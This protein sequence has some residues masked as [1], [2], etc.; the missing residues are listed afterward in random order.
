[1]LG[2]INTLV[3]MEV[4]TIQITITISIIITNT[5]PT[6]TSIPL[7]PI[8]LLLTLKAPNQFPMFNLLMEINWKNLQMANNNLNDLLI[9]NSK[10]K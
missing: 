10:S 5:I 9:I 4:I 1:M 6:P 8:H 3:I 2:D 7:R